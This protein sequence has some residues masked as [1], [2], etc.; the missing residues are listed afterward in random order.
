MLLSDSA[1]LSAPARPGYHPFAG[2]PGKDQPPDH[3][4]LI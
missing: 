3:T 1:V 2:H 4:G